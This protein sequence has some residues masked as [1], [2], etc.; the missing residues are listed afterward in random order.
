MGTM[1]TLNSGGIAG[2]ASKAAGHS[3]KVV[4]DQTD[5]S[6]WEFYYDP[7]KDAT[8]GISSALGAMGAGQQANQQQN[9]TTPFGSN[10]SSGTSS[11][12][13][14]NNSFGSSNSFGSNSGNSGTTNTSPTSPAPPSSTM[15]PPQ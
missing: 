6:L 2:V 13:S 14:N 9:G 5:Y 3:I 8:K 15:P 7:T 4:N 1:G 10:S 12:F 11:P